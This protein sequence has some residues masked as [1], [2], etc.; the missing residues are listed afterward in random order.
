[1]TVPSNARVKLTK[2]R[3]EDAA[4]MFAL[5]SDGRL[6]EFI[7]D[8][9]PRSVDALRARY[10]VLEKETS[11]DGRELWL[12]WVIRASDGNAALGFVQATIVRGG[13]S[14]QIAYVLGSRHWGRGY[15][16]EAVG[17]MLAVLE[18]GYGI[19]V[20]EAEVDW[21]NDRSIRLMERLGFARAGEKATELP[22][23]RASR[24]VVLRLSVRGTGEGRPRTESKD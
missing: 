10:R 16:R 13:D 5:L 14:A 11:P 22:E 9:P 1:M 20:F 15:A 7:P 4:E 8:Q 3:C 17:Q 18:R 24:D 6:Y 23:G 12:N 21:R 2:L 19:A